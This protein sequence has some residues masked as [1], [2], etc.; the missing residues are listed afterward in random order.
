M[1]RSFLASFVIDDNLLC[2]VGYTN[3]C[4]HVYI[5]KT[6]QQ[7]STNIDHYRS[8]THYYSIAISKSEMNP[9]RNNNACRQPQCH[10]V[11]TCHLTGNRFRTNQNRSHDGLLV[12]LIIA[13]VSSIVSLSVVTTNTTHHFHHHHGVFVEGKID[14]NAPHGHRGKLTPYTP[15]P[16]LGLTLTSD[17]EMTLE[18]GESVMKQTLPSDGSSSS[19]GGTAICVQDVHAPVTAV[20]AQILHME[21]YP[22]KV[23]KVLKCENYHVAP[24]H[25]DNNT[26]EKQKK[27]IRIKTKQVLGVLPGY[28][29]RVCGCL[30]LLVGWLV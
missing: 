26:E 12:V 24:T 30:W 27:K 9:H 10:V 20:W 13:I 15:G 23:N 1:S 8:T 21:E 29:V 28:S 22:Q 7:P 17:D 3:V 18:R 5:H 4:I 6:F 14:R 11:A 19:S 16:F 25:H 2:T